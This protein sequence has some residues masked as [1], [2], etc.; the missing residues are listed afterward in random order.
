MRIIRRSLVVFSVALGICGCGSIAPAGSSPAATQMMVERSISELSVDMAAGHL[1]S[2]QLVRAYLERIKAIDRSGPELR[3]VLAINPEALAQARSLDA[4][5]RAGRIRGPLHGIP[6]L[7]KDNI[8]TA[9]SLATT[10]GSLALKNNFAAQDAPLVARLRTA[11]AVILGKTNLSEWSN[12]RSG[13]A[14]SGWSALGG[15]TRNPYA[16]DRNASGSSTGSAVAVSAD[17]APAAVGTDTNGS[18]TAPAAVNGVVALR[19][20]LGLVSRSRVV[21]IGSSQ[22]TPGPIART[23]QDA[24]LLLGIMSGTDPGDMATHQA[25]IRKENYLQWLRTDALKGRRLGVMR[26]GMANY[27]PG[28]IAS[29]EQALEVL[30]AAGAE[31][32]EITEFQ[33]PEELG[34]AAG[35][36]IL[37]EFKTELNAYL[38]STPPA[39]KTRTVADVIAFNRAHAEQE[40]AVFGQEYFEFAQA[41][42]GVNDPAYLEARARS[43]RLAGPEGIDQLLAQYRIDALIAPTANPAWPIKLRN[44][45][46]GPEASVSTLS[47]IAGYPHLTVPMGLVQGLPVGLSFIGPAWADAKLLGFGYAFEQRARARR[48]PTYTRS[49]DQ[50]R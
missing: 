18:I 50:N 31:I 43:K 29:F 9:D 25:D 24:A 41:S 8:E 44:H 36:M 27:Q 13:N 30:R 32:V 5:R 39:V 49:V 34:R 35:T 10:A 1:T 28:V 17:L 2:E 42:P 20:T 22:D 16:V 38:A 40:M 37:A 23:V 21:P 15:L 45:E 19:P 6:V 48:A 7:I 46:R 11:G 12:M 47:A 3:S 14:L 4:E 33:I 26:F